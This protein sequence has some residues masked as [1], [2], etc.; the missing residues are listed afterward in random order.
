MDLFFLLFFFLNELFRILRQYFEPKVLTRSNMLRRFSTDS[1]PTMSIESTTTRSIP[2]DELNESRKRTME[3]VFT[4]DEILFERN[5]VYQSLEQA[6]GSKPRKDRGEPSKIALTI[7]KAQ[8]SSLLNIIIPF[9]PFLPF[10]LTLKT[11]NEK[12]QT[13]LF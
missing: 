10:R 8:Y 11:N 1:F 4:L 5:N 2:F 6:D 9:L 13:V 3:N 12:R 7:S